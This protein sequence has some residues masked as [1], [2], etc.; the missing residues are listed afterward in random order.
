VKRLDSIAALCLLAAGPAACGAAAGGDG[1]THGGAV[2]WV[3]RPAPQ[4]SPPLPA[5]V[6]YPTSAPACRV[7]QIRVTGAKIGFATGNVDERFTFTNISRTSCLLAGV[8]A[9]SALAPDGRLVPL[10]PIR[11]S[12]AGT[13][14]GRLV[15]AAMP[16]GRHVYLDLA[17]EDVTCRL[18]GRPVYHELTFRLPDGRRLITD[19]RLTR[20]CGGWRMS[21]IGLPQRT[22]ATT[23]PSAGSAGTLQVTI[24]LPRTARAGAMLRY[25]VTLTNSTDT[26]VRLDPC[27]SYTEAVYLPSTPADHGL[28]P[29][30]FL[31]CDTIR[32]I[33]PGRHIRY[34]MR[35]R[36][37]A[38]P[39]GLAKFGWHLNVPAEPG[40]GTTLAIRR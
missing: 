34:E 28:S 8:P 11:S 19:T 20:F 32:R 27:P 37:P 33:D 35:F 21:R 10:H 13:F 4:Y 29:A 36:L 16:P 30:F 26:T 40:M 6:P 9:I 7:D 24:S 31:N 38:M 2:A 12:P 17:T 22:T 1:P 39:S 15:P 14:F 23:P 18:D 3:D 5:P 25:F